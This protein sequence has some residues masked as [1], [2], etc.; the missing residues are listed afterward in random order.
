MFV[1]GVPPEQ[2]CKTAADDT[3][4]DQYTSLLLVSRAAGVER[5]LWECPLPEGVTI[6]ERRAPHQAAYRGYSNLV[7]P[8][9]GWIG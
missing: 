9:Y 5:G 8:D 2:G 1:I 4:K 6:A 7:N 3:P